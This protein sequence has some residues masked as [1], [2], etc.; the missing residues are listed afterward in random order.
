MTRL[1]NRLEAVE[2]GVAHPAVPIPL[3]PRISTPE[4]KQALEA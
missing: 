1:K 3:K 2:Q 4:E